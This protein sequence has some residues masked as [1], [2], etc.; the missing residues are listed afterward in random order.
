[1]KPLK[2]PE[3]TI[4]L[5]LGKSSL[6]VT[7][8]ASVILGLWAQLVPQSEEPIISKMM[9]EVWKGKSV[10]QPRAKLKARMEK[11][12]MEKLMQLS[13]GKRLQALRNEREWSQTELS[14]QSKLHR[15]TIAAIE[16]ERRGIGHKVALD[17]AQAFN[18]DYRLFL[19]DKK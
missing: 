3:G 7:V 18:C 12:Q 15:V 13:P 19:N 10:S 2:E 8:K 11:R 6:K 16:T 14:K 9:N 17:L 5:T 4:E 1:M